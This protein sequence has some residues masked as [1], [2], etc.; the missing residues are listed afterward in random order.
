MANTWKFGTILGEL[1]EKD[2]FERKIRTVLGELGWS[3]IYPV[4]F[5]LLWK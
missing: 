2:V 5:A 4:L 1:M 3:R